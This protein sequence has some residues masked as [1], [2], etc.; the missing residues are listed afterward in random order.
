MLHYQ[1]SLE[2]SREKLPLVDVPPS[3]VPNIDFEYWDPRLGMKDERLTP[4]KE[5]KEVLIGPY[6]CQVTR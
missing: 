1:S 6:T 4:N 3:E 2:T 5:L